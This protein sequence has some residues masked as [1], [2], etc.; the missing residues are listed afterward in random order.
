MRGG[1]QRG[2]VIP[3]QPGAGFVVVEAE[4]AFEL[5]VVELDFHRRRA[6]QASRPG[7]VERGRLEIQ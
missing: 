4:L 1:D 2:V 3:P 6:S 5:F 7:W